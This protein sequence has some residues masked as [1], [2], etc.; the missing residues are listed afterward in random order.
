MG[1]IRS[2]GAVGLAFAAALFLT[3]CGNQIPEMSE[4][5]EQTIGEYTAMLLLKYDANS[6]SR[7]VD[8]V[9]EEWNEEKEAEAEE[10][11]ELPPEEDEPQGMDPV[12]DTPVVD[13]PPENGMTDNTV[14]SMEAFF[15]L[16]A[17]MTLAFQ[18]TQTT[19]SY[20]DGGEMENYFTLDATNGKS[21]LVLHYTLSNQSGADQN[22]DF[23]NSSAVFKVTVNGDYTR[24]ALVT[25]LED[26]M[27]V[28][29]GTL[30]AGESKDLVLLI[31]IDQS[32]VDNISSVSL[33]VQDDSNEYVSTLM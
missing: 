20:P 19:A 21:L 11:P 7:L 9:L 4:D 6:R 8:Y 1:K 32:M 26:D 15:Q 12:A 14:S 24:T 5:Q 2:C 22:V 16:P 27:S 33:S 28:Y 31:E 23:L 17:G 3:G 13:M 30:A 25:M 29:A 10:E 18:N